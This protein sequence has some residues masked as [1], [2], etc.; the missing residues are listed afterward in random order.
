MSGT[1]T[2]RLDPETARILKELTRR[3]NTTQSHVIKKALRDRWKSSDV[4]REP[5]AREVYA[6]MN[7]PHVKPKHDRAR[8]IEELLKEI[9]IEKKR[10]GTF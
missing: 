1:V 2:F 10:K 9:L 7:I 5:S 3:E 8:H 6:A 4:P